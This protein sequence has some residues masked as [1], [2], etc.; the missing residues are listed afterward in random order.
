LVDYSKSIILT[1]DE[2]IKAMEEKAARK[3]LH[4]KEKELKKR[5]AELTKGK[6]AEDKIQKEAAKR[7][8]LADAM[9]WRAFSEKWSAKAVARAGEE[10]HQLI[11]SGASPPPGAYVRKF[12]TFCPKIC[13][14]NQT[15]VQERM[16]VRREGRSPNP[17]LT[18]IPP[19]WVHQPDTRFHVE[20]HMDGD[21]EVA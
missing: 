10:L 4:E 19:P 6:R 3:E 8:R 14:K 17:A 15:I 1:G 11:K 21:L 9:A 12:V 13:R 2:Y 5:E 18:T 16:K 20:V 7:Q